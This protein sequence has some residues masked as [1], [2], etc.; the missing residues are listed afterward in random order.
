MLD[1]QEEVNVNNGLEV[2]LINKWK[3]GIKTK[4][5]LQEHKHNSNITPITRINLPKID[6]PLGIKTNPIRIEAHKSP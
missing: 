6:S 3:K 5:R 4:I 1:F 2:T